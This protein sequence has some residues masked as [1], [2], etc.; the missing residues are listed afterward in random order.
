MGSNFFTCQYA[1][2]ELQQVK[3][4]KKTYLH[5]LQRS[6][7]LRLQYLVLVSWYV[8]SLMKHDVWKQWKNKGKRRLQC[9]EGQQQRSGI[10]LWQVV[11][12]LTINWRGVKNVYTHEQM[13][14]QNR[15]IHIQLYIHLWGH[16]AKLLV[17]S[18][19]TKIYIYQWTWFCTC[20]QSDARKF[21]SSCE[22]KTDVWA[23]N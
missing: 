5:Q 4:K 12:T 16:F 9:R 22:S 7:C 14:I 11:E 15:Y 2:V 8:L 6:Y 10:L 20:L 23:L 13:Y 3:K 1:D 21:G 19:W 17:Y 18:I